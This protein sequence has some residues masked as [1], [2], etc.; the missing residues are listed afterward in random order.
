MDVNLKPGANHWLGYG[1][2]YRRA[3]FDPDPLID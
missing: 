2:I 3:L 1:G